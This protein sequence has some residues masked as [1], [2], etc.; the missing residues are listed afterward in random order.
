M[1]RT[2]MPL[3]APPRAVE[4]VAAACAE[5][6]AAHHRIRHQ[7]FVEEQC[8]FDPSDLDDHDGAPGVIRV[9]GLHQSV[10]AGTVRL[11]PLD[12]EGW[13]WQGDR[14]AVLPEFRTHGLGKPLVRFAVAT[15]GALGGGEM[16]AHI[17]LANV[18]FFE[19]LGWRRR[20][21]VE[22]YVGTPHQLMSI[23]LNQGRAIRA[24]L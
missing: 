19:Q 3:A 10:P 7:V 20:G 5:E 11:F 8:L 1:T 21:D 23:G 12:A 17:Q 6:L 4:C 2:P 22:M 13:L 15:A 14:L 9:L 24:R 18:A 16:K